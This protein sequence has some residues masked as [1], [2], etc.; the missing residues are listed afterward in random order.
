MAV[1]DKTRWAL[2]GI[3]PIL[4][5]P[6]SDQGAAEPDALARLADDAI[7][8][9]VAG[10]IYPA[11]ASE[12]AK[13]HADERRDLT[14]VVVEQTDGRVPVIVGVSSG[15]AED[16]IALAGH[17][18]KIGAAGILAQA[19]ASCEGDPHRLRKF[20]GA[21]AASVPL[22]MMIQDLDWQGTGMRIELICELF[23]TLPTFRSIKVET[24]AAGLKYSRILAATGGRLHVAGG[25][26]VTQMLDGLER[27][28]HAFM[29]EAS[30][31]RIYC[32]IMARYAAGDR[33]S[34]RDLFEKLLPVLAF[35]NQHLDVSIQF[36]KRVLVAKGIFGTHAVRPPILRLDPIQERT[37]AA[38]VRRVLGLESE[39]RSAQSR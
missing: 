9:G 39:I 36:F 6:F 38:L 19:P 23:E 35:S 2:D 17:A 4:Q 20:F 28:V 32:A 3:V 7:A 30:M 1:A 5:T 33:D 16:S 34:A 31:V 13:L 27:G 22:D 12:V 25:W 8:G 10:L 11:V 37:A 24:V 29:P 21:L 15:S 18:A 26:A 14:Q